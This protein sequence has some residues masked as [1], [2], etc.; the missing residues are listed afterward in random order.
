MY[1]Q[2]YA[3]MLRAIAGSLKPV[4]MDASPRSV[5]VYLYT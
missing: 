4:V 3:N 5:F 1:I 2:V